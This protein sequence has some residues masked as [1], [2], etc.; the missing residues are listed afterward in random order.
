MEELENLT[1]D[2]LYQI[3]LTYG[4]YEEI[5]VDIETFLD[6]P[7]YIGNYF[8]EDGIYPFWREVLKEIYPTPFSRD[9]WLV[10]LRGAIGSGKSTAACV[11]MMYDAYR[12][13]CLKVPQSSFPGLLSTTKLVFAVFNSTL[14]L[15]ADVVWDKISQMISTS[16]YFSSKVE[17]AKMESLPKDEKTL[18]PK[19]IDFFVGSRMGHALGKAIYSSIIDE[20]NFEVITD[21]TTKTF[22]SLIRRMESRFSSFTPDGESVPYGTLW[23]VSSEAEKSSPLNKILDKYKKVRGVKVVKTRRWDKPG[24]YSGRTFKVFIGSSNIDPFVI[25]DSRVEE[26]MDDDLV[27]EVP[28]EFRP[29][30]N[31]D[32][33]EALR[34]LAGEPV[35]GPRKLFPKVSILNKAAVVTPLFTSD[36]IELHP[37][38]QLSTYLVTSEYFVK[39][40]HPESPRHI[41]LDLAESGDLA[42]VAGSYIRGY[43]TKATRDPL[44]FD[45]IIETLPEVVVEWVVGIKAYP[46]EQI[47]FYRIREFLLWL[48]GLGYPIMSLSADGFQSTDMLQ[49]MSRAGYNTGKLSV[50]RTT[51]PYFS[52]RLA[53]HEERVKIPRVSLLLDELSRLE[54]SPDYKKVD[55][56]AD[57]SKDLADAVCGSYYH[58]LDPKN[59]DVTTPMIN[60]EPE[61]RSS[62][63]DSLKSLWGF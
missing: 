5:P 30:F 61:K 31:V 59:R 23:L 10:G 16:P 42:G 19:R 17:R 34:D 29:Y 62:D 18:F 55:H 9:Y 38:E 12:L 41:H 52:F 7:E 43:I 35:G 50:D 53:V 25:E 44:T 6:N 48:S 33:S 57:S 11:G 51:D 3:L 47:P 32:V 26:S 45:E 1:N 56:P 8:G 24:D 27:I 46:G 13:L 4:N 40:I 54:I 39:P 22:R 28:I 58:F 14:T 20:A 37:D 15:A 21:Q 63:M 49:L 36:V 60:V 2:E